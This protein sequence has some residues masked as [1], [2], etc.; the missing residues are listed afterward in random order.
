MEELVALLTPLLGDKADDVGRTLIALIRES[1]GGVRGFFDR[2][3]A[4]G[5]GSNLDRW[6]EGQVTEV[7]PALVANLFGAGSLDQLAERYEMSIETVTQAA[8]IAL[9]ILAKLLAGEAEGGSRTETETAQNTSDK[10][11][12]VWALIAVVLTIVA[13]WF[14]AGAGQSQGRNIYEPI[15]RVE[16]EEASDPSKAT[17]KL[18][19]AEFQIAHEGL[20]IKYSGK[21]PKD[22]VGHLQSVLEE[23]LGDKASG[24]L[25]GIDAAEPKWMPHFDEIVKLMT[26]PKRVLEIEIVG[27]DLTVHGGASDLEQFHTELSEMA[28]RL[29][30][31]CDASH[32]GRF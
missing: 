17:I 16:H 7:S 1:E 8:G 32:V 10:P 20:G 9:P 22:H 11:P 15:Q 31:R 24:A 14:A 13:I 18:A 30:I 5:F 26:N 6:L 29:D 19:Q 21:V 4:A 27:D 3:R 28:E 25:I 2:V 23:V 12:L